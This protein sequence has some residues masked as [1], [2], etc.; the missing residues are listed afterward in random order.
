M[1]PARE[2]ICV[3]KEQF[4]TFSFWR[5]L[6]VVMMWGCTYSSVSALRWDIERNTYDM[7]FAVDRMQCV[8]AY[9]SVMLQRAQRFIFDPSSVSSSAQRLSR[10][11]IQEEF[12]SLQLERLLHV[13]KNCVDL[14]YWPSEGQFA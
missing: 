9:G 8:E 12:C 5:F 7:Q 4:D 1:C 10:N 11:D 13:M 2:A 3:E 14:C 6:V